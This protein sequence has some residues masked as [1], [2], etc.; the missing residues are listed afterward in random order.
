MSAAAV[1]AVSDHGGMDR[2]DL[3]P[4]DQLHEQLELGAVIANLPELLLARAIDDGRWGVIV[5]LGSHRFAQVLVT[6]EGLFA[7]E[8]V[9]NHFLTEEHRLSTADE[10]LLLE[11]GFEEPW[12][13]GEP[14][15]NFFA[16]LDG[17]GAALEAARLMDVAL[18][19]VLGG[20]SRDSCELIIR[21]LASAS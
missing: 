13:P 4:G 16:E 2:S 11:A 20:S 17:R 19:A 9:S 3:L 1:A 15:P 8:C 10:A 21:P 12:G 14:H 7:V 6:E 18:R 5:E